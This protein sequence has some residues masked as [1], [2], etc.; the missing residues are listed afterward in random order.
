MIKYK[1]PEDILK[2]KKSG[3]ILHYVLEEVKKQIKPGVSATFLD[4]F[5]YDMIVEKGGKP[6]FLNYKPYGAKKGFPNSVCVSINEEV[7]HGT[8]Y[9]GKV[10]KEGDLVSI[11][12]GVILD[13]YYSDSAFTVIV[14]RGSEKDEKMV[15]V[16][17]ESL[18]QAICQCKIGNTL[19][20]IGYAINNYV[21]QNGFVTIKDLVGHG[22]G[23]DLHEDPEVFNYGFPKKGL[24]L[25]EGMVIAIEP[26]ITYFESYVKQGKNEAYVTS[27][28]SPAA[29][30]EHTVA[31]TKNGP[32]ILT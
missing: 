26:M 11:D 16:C 23:F 18:N 14:G 20:D 2:I 15:S 10:I 29:H 4:S 17:K 25:K 19:G 27:D 8:C 30:F 22:V 5:A 32:L 24:V 9:P 3:E 6:A 7:V 13:G 12:C 31:I 28:L 1:K 21:V